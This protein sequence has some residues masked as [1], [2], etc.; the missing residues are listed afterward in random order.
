MKAVILVAGFGSRLRPLTDT[1][2]K[3]LLPLGDTTGLHRMVSELKKHGITEIVFVTGHFEEKIKA[4]VNEHFPDITAHFVRNDKYDKTNN[5]YS[6]LMAEPYVRGESFVKFDG[7]VVF[8]PAV[9]RL[10]LASPDD[11]NY[12]CLDKCQVNEEVLKVQLGDGGEVISMSQHIPVEK[13]A[14]E[15]LGIEKI[16]AQFSGQLFD[17]LRRI[18]LDTKNWQEYYEFAY[19]DL[20]SQKAMPFKCADVTGYNWVEVDN[21]EDYRLAHQYFVPELPVR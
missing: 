10:L 19:E 8:D 3:A 11:A 4:Y 9:L 17:T 15:S 20:L 18:M 16:S 14:G 13:A 6:L 7:D 2:P 12:V 21:Q 5:G 1:T